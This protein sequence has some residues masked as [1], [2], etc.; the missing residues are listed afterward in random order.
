MEREKRRK[1]EQEQSFDAPDYSHSMNEN[2]TQ[3]L[4]NVYKKNLL[5]LL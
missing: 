1:I 5:I 4:S 3:E 2:I